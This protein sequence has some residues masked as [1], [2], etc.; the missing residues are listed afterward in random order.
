MRFREAGFSKT[1]TGDSLVRDKDLREPT[2]LLLLTLLLME[3]GLKIGYW[4]TKN[5][6][7]KQNV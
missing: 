2:E 3:N 7:L 5:N 6:D 1:K 4:A